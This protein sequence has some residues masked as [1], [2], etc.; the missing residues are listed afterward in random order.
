MLPA[1]KEVFPPNLAPIRSSESSGRQDLPSLIFVMAVL[2]A[3]VPNRRAYAEI[4]RENL[5]TLGDGR[6]VAP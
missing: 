2:L 3:E 1:S 6:P 4:G 5:A